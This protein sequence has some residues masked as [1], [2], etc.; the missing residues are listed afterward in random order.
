MATLNQIVKD[1]KQVVR[2]LKKVL[3][4]LDTPQEKLERHLT[5]ILR[6]RYKVPEES[7]LAKIAEYSN[8]MANGLEAFLQ[9]LRAGFPQ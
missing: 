2:N 8:E 3:K 1:R 4:L 5:R 7:D 6:R 9:V